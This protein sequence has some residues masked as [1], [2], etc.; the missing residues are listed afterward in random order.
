M[1][2]VYFLLQPQLSK[3][4]L[5]PW[6]KRFSL[7]FYRFCFTLQAPK[8]A[9]LR[10]KGS[11]PPESRVFTTRLLPGTIAAIFLGA[12]RSAGADR[13]RTGGLLLAKQAFSQLNYSPDSGLLA[14][15]GFLSGPG[16]AA[17][18]HFPWA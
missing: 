1:L 2:K 5:P 16:P 14:P 13:D 11:F 6:G 8:L 3:I 15:V 7:L 12:A 18:V 10:L 4:R 17:P 9:F